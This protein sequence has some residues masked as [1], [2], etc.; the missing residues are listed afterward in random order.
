MEKNHGFPRKNIYT[1]T[2]NQL[3][4]MDSNKHEMG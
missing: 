1:W 4:G 3:E 2:L